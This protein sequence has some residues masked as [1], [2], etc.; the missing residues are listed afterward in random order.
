MPSTLS[1]TAG[2]TAAASLRV[3]RDAVYRAVWRWHFYAGLL[4]LP[5][6]ILLSATGA[7]YLFKAEINATVFA[8]R[9]VVASSGRT[10]LGP[11]RLIFNAMQA[12]PEGNPLSYTEPAGPTASA[13][14]TLAEGGGK[15]LL[16][17][18]P[19]TGDVLDRVAADREFFGIVRGLHS[20]TLFGTAA[21][22]LI[23][24]VAG[25]AIILVV[26]GAYLWWPQGKGQRRGRAV[27]LRETPRRRVWWRD[28]HAATGLFAGAGLLFL[29]LTGLPWSVW[30]GQELR[31]WSNR[32]GL[33][34]PTQLWAGK[35]V[36]TV[37]M[38]AR[39]ES[40]GW[41]LEDALMPRSA[42]SGAPSLGID[43]AVATLRDMA[44]PGGFEL[45]LPLGETGVYAASAYP[46]DV[47]GQRMVSLDR[48]SG[49][50]IIDVRFA[51]L[52]PVA[53][54]IQYG[55]GLHK[56]E[57][58]GRANQLAMLAFCLG[59]ILLSVT[60]AVMW[61]KRRPAGRLGTPP[62]PRDRRVV[63]T[64]TGLMLGLGAL[65]PLTGLAI[66]A[67]LGLDLAAQGLRL[68]ART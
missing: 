12:V 31:A 15:I 19:Y 14:V 59:T 42:P 51:D 28:L 7:L 41:A 1:G 37:P 10:P 66:L 58:W 57:F 2:F 30:W 27:S 68:A 4:C 67:L 49:Q 32:A 26:T 6:L 23:E 33:G 50:P 43:R 9:T 36:S 52:G 18:D 47:T 61:W 21:N 17:L 34:Q 11:D 5:F 39:L 24:I 35:A 46:R 64:V 25:F 22:A 20:L 56:G 3:S 38:G 29:A 55:I 44:L 62:W 8:H 65:F 13:L 54:A 40:A 48:Y 53:R 16:Y 63:A 45:A 60:A